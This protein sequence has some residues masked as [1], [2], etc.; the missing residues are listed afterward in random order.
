ML[1]KER[2]GK[3]S[4]E[5]RKMVFGKKGMMR[6]ERTEIG[7]K[8]ECYD[9]GG[10]GC[11]D[12]TRLRRLHIRGRGMVFNFRTAVTHKACLLLRECRWRLGG[13]WAFDTM[14]TVIS[15]RDER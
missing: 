5:K 14:W 10:R 6:G 1:L 8:V 13:C 11:A 15:S 7:W 3:T 12:P 2:I 4:V 9:Y